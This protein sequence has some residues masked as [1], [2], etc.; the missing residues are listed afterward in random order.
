MVPICVHNMNVFYRYALGDTFPEIFESNH[1][2]YTIYF[3]SINRAGIEKQG[4]HQNRPVKLGIKYPREIKHKSS[5]CE[6]TNDGLPQI[7]KA[8]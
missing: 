1:H 7:L 6:C 3:L 8:K 5:T 2:F 4:S